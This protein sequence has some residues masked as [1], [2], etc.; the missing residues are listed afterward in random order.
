LFSGD[1]HR[2][3]FPSQKKIRWKTIGKDR[4]PLTTK[5]MLERTKIV[6][7]IKVKRYATSAP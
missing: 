6:S 2:K 7:L 3:R 1:T 5:K 4:T